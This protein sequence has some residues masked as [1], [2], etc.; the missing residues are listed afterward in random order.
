[1]MDHLPSPFNNLDIVRSKG[2]VSCCYLF[3][4]HSDGKF[5]G[6]LFPGG[7]R[8]R[9][10]LLNSDYS[11]CIFF[12]ECRNITK[13]RRGFLAA[14]LPKCAGNEKRKCGLINDCT[15][16]IVQGIVRCP[17]TN[18]YF[19]SVHTWKDDRKLSDFANHCEKN[20]VSENLITE[21]FNVGVNVPIASFQLVYLNAILGD[22]NL[23]HPSL[24]PGSLLNQNILLSSELS[25]NNPDSIHAECSL[26][27]CDVWYDKCFRGFETLKVDGNCLKRFRYFKKRRR[28]CSR[29]YNKHL[30]WSFQ[31][32]QTTLYIVSQEFRRSQLS[33]KLH[34][35]HSEG[36]SSKYDFYY[37]VP[38]K[39]EYIEE[40]IS[41][42]PVHHKDYDELKK[43]FPMSIKKLRST[44]HLLVKKRRKKIIT[45]I[46]IIP[47]NS[48]KYK[49][50][51]RPSQPRLCS[52]GG[53]IV[54]FFEKDV[55][56][57]QVFPDA[58]STPIDGIF[59]VQLSR[60][61][62]DNFLGFRGC[63]SVF[64]GYQWPFVTEIHDD[65]Y[66]L[67]S[68]TYK[69]KGLI[70]S[71]VPH[72]GNF[73]MVGRRTSK[74]STG[75]MVA[76]DTSQHEYFRDSMDSSLLPLLRGII[77]TLQEE[78]LIANYTSGETIMSSM[79]KENA[80][81]DYKDLCPQTIITQSHFANVVHFDQCFA[82]P[83][84]AKKVTENQK[85][86]MELL[87]HL[88]NIQN[89]P[90]IKK[91]KT[92]D[93]LIPKSTTCCW[94][95]REKCQRSVMMQFFVGVSAGFAFD[96]SSPVTSD[97]GKIGGTFQSSLF[98]HCTSVPLWID[99]EKQLVHILPPFEGRNYNFAWGSNGKKKKD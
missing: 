45:V 82:D 56:I 51:G 59:E 43:K 37:L 86:P 46:R 40:T 87:E 58:K 11:P 85:N 39:F 42:A 76:I 48:E 83:E 19:L 16:V 60:N 7:Y 22:Q 71:S 23:L 17:I 34:K 67:F 29:S 44:L 28:S 81:Y 33:L 72:Q 27:S 69:R 78:A 4:A 21:Y 53:Q 97:L 68:K 90:Q 80:R 91:D 18:E 5:V 61:M 77:N 94:T 35:C 14:M 3:A 49:H 64:R 13:H 74:Q 84:S 75:S 93:I 65:V 36:S 88:K 54:S 47:T 24:R 32:E 50:T 8:I 1:M 62:D 73:E 31:Q 57:Y 95:L 92:D 55:E 9:R 52:P 89:N 20:Y 70:R 30:P 96:I 25:D 41:F 79:K 63:C 38:F 6:Y 12:M 15:L 98:D 26:T 99:E 66:E 10:K 2:S